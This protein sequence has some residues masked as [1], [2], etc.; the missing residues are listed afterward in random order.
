MMN[1]DHTQEALDEYY[2]TGI[3]P[4]GDE[5]ADDL[6]GQEQAFYDEETGIETE[7]APAKGALM[8]GL[9]RLE[10]YVDQ[11]IAEIDANEPDI[12]RIRE[13]I[14]THEWHF[15]KT[16]PEIP[17]W[18]CLRKDKGDIEEF[19]WFA[20]TIREHSIEG[21][22]HGRTYYY[23]YLDG[24]KYWWMDPTPEECDLINRDKVN[25]D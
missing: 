21:Q 22:F 19:T 14:D 4:T 2:T 13:F 7:I 18:Y 17:H 24:Y 12:A 8:A 16:M 20:K 10:Q 15:A 9:E 11:K 6:D 23:F 5:I 25:E 1:R 3:D